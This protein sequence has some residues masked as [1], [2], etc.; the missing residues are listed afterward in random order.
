MYLGLPDEQS[1]TG[2][3]GDL[4]AELHDAHPDRK[5]EGVCAK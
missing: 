1:G 2:R 4:R 5:T 3:Q